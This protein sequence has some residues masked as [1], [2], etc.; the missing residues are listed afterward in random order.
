MTA[1]PL[2]HFT[3]RSA[4]R[5]GCTLPSLAPQGSL[6]DCTLPASLPSRRAGGADACGVHG[7]RRSLA[8][9]AV[10]VW[11]I[12]PVALAADWVIVPGQ[13]VGPIDARTSEARLIELFGAG[14]VARGS[15]DVE[16]G[17][18]MPATLLFP[19]DPSR[20]ALVVWRDPETRTSPESVLI[21]GGQSVWKT[22]KGI[23]L[24]TP[25]ATLRRLNGRPL[26]VTGFG[27]DLGGTV[28]DCNGGNLVELGRQTRDGLVG[29]T[30]VLRLEP[31]PVLQDT[32]AF[33]QTAG[34]R[35]FSSDGDAMRSLNPRV[36]EIVVDIAAQ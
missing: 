23:G 3:R 33:Q 7:R 27:W 10:L 9:I 1:R 32:P 36:Y 11:A 24:G 4:G 20:R 29:R 18:A 34:D 16:P 25:L 6:Q 15:F 13:R 28:L 31:D 35:E 30:L 12:V 22:D 8:A 21:R 2:R 26:T 17:V 14:N 19:R 5:Q